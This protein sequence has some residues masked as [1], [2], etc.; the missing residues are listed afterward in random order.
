MK[1][2][3]SRMFMAGLALLAG[4]RLAPLPIL[5]QAAPSAEPQQKLEAFVVTGSYIP[6]VESSVEAG[7]SP[8][9]RVDRKA[10]DESGLTS[11]AELLQKITVSNANAVPISNNALGFTP[12]ASTISLRGL[13]PEAT[14]ILINGR[15]VAAYPVGVGGATAFVDLGSIPLA[16]V[17]AIEVL[18]D[19]AS[20]IYGADAV[21][22][23]V[24]VKLRRGLS[25]SEASLSYGNTT[26]KDSHE[27]VASLATGVNTGRVSL[28]VGLNLYRKGGIKDADRDYSR[29]APFSSANSSP[30]NLELSRFSAAA[31][32]GQPV[33]API[34]GVANFDFSFFANSGA[35]AGNTGARPAAQYTYSRDRA[36]TFNPNEFSSS[37]P[38][39]RRGGG[40]LSGEVKLF[41]TDNIAAYGDLSWQRVNVDYELAPTAT[42]DFETPGQV[43]LVIPARTANPIL[44]VLDFNTFSLLSVLPGF[45]VRLG[46]F[47]GP[48]TR[49]VN[50]TAQRLAPAGASNPFNPFNQDISGDS[51]G[52]LAEFGNRLIRSRNDAGLITAGIKGDNVAGKWNFDASITGSSIRDVTRNRATSA[53]RFNQV[54]N[55]ASPVFDPRSPSYLGTSTPYNP[56]GY[57]R[58]P[59]AGNAALADYAHVPFSDDHKSTL[60]QLAAV[61]STRE[62]LR[63]PGGAVGLAFGAEFRREQLNQNP[64]EFGLAGDLVGFAPSAVTRAQRKV[65][66]FFAELRVPILASLEAGLAGRHEVF[67]T[68]GQEKTVPKA[69]LRWQPFSRQLTLRASY[70]EGFREPSLFER[71]SSP[72]SALSPILDPRDFFLEPEQRITLRGNRRLAAEKTDYFNTGFVWSPTQPRIKG[73][74]LGADFWAV[75]RTGTV[76]ANPQNTVY[77]FF[78]LTPGGMLPGESVQFS[79]SGSISSVNALFYNVGR[80]VVEGWDFSGGYQL[81]T[82]ALGRFDFSTIWTLT[83]RFDR[84]AVAGATLRSVLGQ[85]ST[86]TAA[87]GYLKLKGRG[88][89][90]WSYRNWGVVL[91]CHYTDGFDDFDPLGN[92]YRVR[93]RYLTDAQVSYTFR[94]SQKAWLR[95]TRLTLGARNVADWDPPQ[96]YGNGGNSS[97]YPG[98]LYTSEGR[99]IY[100]S[101]NRKF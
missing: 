3:R 8:V 17:E 80:T 53:T 65:S 15:R 59:I 91:V 86:S 51:R 54:V 11:T 60:V 27:F 45:P 89:V 42:G 95:D 77:R 87:D 41:R 38:E 96:A 75:T 55:A 32:I 20:A 30:F 29:V 35:D 56:F 18:K 50:G 33:G 37:Y 76:Q 39:V 22:G 36:S 1:L 28:L 82:D 94:G 12:G 83:T 26:N 61:G 23:V 85:D 19:G 40:M 14:L 67:H 97:S 4:A 90:N 34:R 57:Y 62:L 49:F 70:S 84:A 2:I 74:T 79:S 13:G 7:A 43:S 78:G 16:A 73:L 72:I 71:Y 25:G 44:T 9:V 21:A 98:G 48:G 58:N 52:R 99:F 100:F 6:S 5:A 10:I 47:P 31:A 64:S 93:D 88:I 81:L 63:L 101:A 46:M 92:A 69:T 68:S 66:G 24:N